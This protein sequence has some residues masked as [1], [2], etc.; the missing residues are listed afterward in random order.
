MKRRNLAL[1]LI[2]CL[3]F[4]TGCK[5][6]SDQVKRPNM[7]SFESLMGN[8]LPQWKYVRTQADLDNL[9]FFKRLYESNIEFLKAPPAEYKIPKVLHYIWMGPKAFPRESVEYV[10]TWMTN[11]PGWKV[12]LW[13]DRARKAP[14]DG[15]EIKKVQDFQWVQLKECFDKSENWAEKSDLLR[16]EILYQQGGIFVDHDVECFKS[17][18]A[19]NRA[20]DL[21]CGMEVPYPTS[22]ESSVLPTNNLVGARPGHPVLKGCMEW[23]TKDWDQIELD[24]PGKDRD[25]L[26]NRIAHRTFYSL[27]KLMK[28]RA[29]QDGNR[30]I[31]LPTMYFNSPKIDWALYAQHKYMGTWF[32]NESTAEKNTRQRL[33]YISKKVNKALLLSTIF[34]AI[35]I[36]G[37]GV[38]ISL[39]VRKKKLI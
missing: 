17:F 27:G 20:Y 26:I 34:G 1:G 16:V 25:S 3:A 2:L 37:F 28:E 18:D 19:M 29:G 11:H 6:K 12:Y 5:K 9:T 24:Y 13:T 31:A 14:L 4:V 32:T 10:K 38:V 15:I 8:E 22:L 7:S 35:N 23:L 33:M 30:D 36:I 21:F 39:L